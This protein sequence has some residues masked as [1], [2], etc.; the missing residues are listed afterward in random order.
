MKRYIL[1]PLSPFHIQTGGSDHEHVDAFAHSDT[2]SA[3][4]IQL[5]FRQEGKIES[6]PEKLP[7]LVSSLLPG[8][9]WGHDVKHFFPKPMGITFDA[10]IYDH[11]EFKKAAFLEDSLFKDYANGKDVSFSFPEKN[12]QAAHLKRGSILTKDSNVDIG[13][14]SLFEIEN[15][16][17]VHISTQS[18]ATP[19]NFAKIHFKPDV[20][21]VFF[22]EVEPT[23]EAVFSALIRLLGD[24]GIGA[25]GT[26]GLGQFEVEKID[27][28]VPQ[29]EQK[30][31]FFL[32]IG[33]F[34]PTESCLSNHLSLKTSCYKLVT[35]RG[36]VSELAL[37]RQAIRAIT[38]GSVLHCTQKPEGQHALVVDKENVNVPKKIP[39]NVY[40]DLRGFFIPLNIN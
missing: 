14:G 34:S 4:L 3:A 8:I 28:V 25:D 10:S 35:R 2:L 9:I 13:S 33:L 37:R 15:M 29:T 5:W 18:T 40:R 7:F 6:F 26:V 31:N 20:R 24:E 39:H 30:A 27:H 21:L 16:T 11:K 22:A 23:H 17:R 1:K 12:K 38:E 32:N 19:F 36:W